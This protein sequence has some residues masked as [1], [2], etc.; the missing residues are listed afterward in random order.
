MLILGLGL[1]SFWGSPNRCQADGPTDLRL[2]VVSSLFRDLHKSAIEYLSAPLRALLQTQT[3]LTG[4][5]TSTTDPLSLARQL[6]D[7]HV[8]VAV[9]HGFEFAWAQQKYPRLQPLVVVGNSQPLQAHLIVAH[10]SPFTTPSDLKGK[11]LALPR[12]SRA[13]LHLFLERRCALPEKGPREYFSKIVR[14]ID[15][16][17]ALEM[18]LSGAVQAV[19]VEQSH[20]ESYRA[21]HPEDFGK[22]RV[23]LKSE[24][25]PAGVIAYR[26]GAIPEDTVQ[27][28]RTGLL[29]AHKTPQSQELLKLCRMPGFTLPPPD[30][31]KVLQTIAKA[32]PAPSR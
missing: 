27:V 32:Y 8:N 6:Q 25:F 9:F 19:L 13:H 23:L 20:L 1:L 28:I 15:G 7:D 22:L 18:V 26:K 16:D 14:P 2:G 5:L 12:Q 3:G 17:D 10:S 30:F 31:D 24:V 4:E 29:S 11:A 21:N